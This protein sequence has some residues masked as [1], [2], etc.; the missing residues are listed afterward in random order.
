MSK[1]PDVGR[2]ILDEKAKLA[3]EEMLDQLK[4]QEDCIRINSSKLV[5]WIVAYFRN[6]GFEHEQQA[7]IKAHF[8]SK[9]YL[10]KVMSRSSS[11]ED[12]SA[13]LQTVLT[14]MNAGAER[15]KRRR[16]K[17]SEIMKSA[18]SHADEEKSGG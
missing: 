18:S 2:V 11:E 12:L 13:A 7:I 6:S 1:T 4:K 9:E 3:V 5:S 15:R 8:N 16:E 14:R 17:Q 10:K